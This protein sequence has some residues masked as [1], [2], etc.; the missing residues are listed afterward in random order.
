MKKQ[1]K[2]ENI[3]GSNL[4]KIE[5][6]L[7]KEIGKENFVLNRETNV[8]TINFLDEN[9]INEDSKRIE[10][11]IQDIDEDIELTE[12]EI[13]PITRKVLILENLDCANCAMKV[14]RLAK[15]ELE[16]EF[17]VVD[18]AS[19]K[20][21]IETSNEDVINNLVEKVQDIATSVDSNIIVKEPSKG[22][23]KDRE[24]KIDTKRK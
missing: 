12:R 8:L 3:S 18:F 7:T 2:I 16:H 4:Y 24:F 17:I 22:K 20:F 13:K 14:E 11:Y 19:T 10:N 5:V 6:Y 9:K 21:I 15:R 23:P 1:Y